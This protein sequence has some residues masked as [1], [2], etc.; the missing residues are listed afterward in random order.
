MKRTLTQGAVAAALATAL[1]M[2]GCAPTATRQG[3]GE[4]IDDSVITSKVKAALLADPEV[5]GTAVNVETYRGTVQLSGFVDSP[6]EI[7]RAAEKAYEVK[8]VN[9][10]RNDLKVKPVR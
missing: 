9:S 5:K 2:T 1:L 7:A 3:T 8:G 4:Y 10:V 6:S